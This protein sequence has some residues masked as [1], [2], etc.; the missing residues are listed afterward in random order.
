MEAI[1]RILT[2]PLAAVLAAMILAGCAVGPKPDVSAVPDRRANR[3]TGQ[4]PEARPRANANV[5]PIART[6]PGPAYKTDYQPVYPEAHSARARPAR[7]LRDRRDVD[8]N[9]MA[10]IGTLSARLE[11]RDCGP[12]VKCD[13][14]AALALAAA[15]K[16]GDYV[17]L[18]DE[19]KRERR[20]A[21][22]DSGV[23]LVSRG[24]VYRVGDFDLL[25]RAAVKRADDA[26]RR[27]EAAERRAVA[28]HRRAAE[29][30]Q[31]LDARR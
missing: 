2:R 24:V 13:A 8:F 5:T 3:Q 26:L 1:A 6:D 29:A 28:A 9:K 23:S 15:A 21:E 20:S 14:T 16:G 18:T 27:A 4:A 31:A 11:P 22:P 25:A 10:E 7:L 17:L 19:N 12:G 30:R